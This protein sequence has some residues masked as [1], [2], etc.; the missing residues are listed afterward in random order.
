MPWMPNHLRAYLPIGP[1][2]LY[3]LRKRQIM[4]HA[5]KAHNTHAPWGS[6]PET[7]SLAELFSNILLFPMS[8][9]GTVG[10]VKWWWSL[11]P[12]AHQ[13]WAF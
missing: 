11:P 9:P 10:G 5:A 8:H 3:G 12:P 13:G 4:Q 2:V 6:H 1:E 7:S